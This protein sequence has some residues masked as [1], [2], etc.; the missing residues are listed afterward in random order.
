[1]VCITQAE[2]AVTEKLHQREWKG[3]RVWFKG[4]INVFTSETITNPFYQTEDEALTLSLFNIAA[5]VR[6]PKD[7]AVRLLNSFE[8]GSNEMTKFV[9]QRLDS[10]IVNF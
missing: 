2:S 7:A 8:L 4:C 5:G 9:E 10:N 1:M 6:M 3:R